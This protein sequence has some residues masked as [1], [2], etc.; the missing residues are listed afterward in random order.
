MQKKIRIG[1]RKS[2]LALVQTNI[3]KEKI[4]EAFP[5]LEVEIAELSTQ[6]DEQ[7]DRSLTSF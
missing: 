6:G 2:M 3:V 4:L 5:D 1:T 7:L